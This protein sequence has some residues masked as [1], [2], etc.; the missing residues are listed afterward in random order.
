[1]KID[2]VD[3]GIHFFVSFGDSAGF[4]QIAELPYAR[5]LTL[6]RTMLSGADADVE[7]RHTLDEPTYA[8]ALRHVKEVIHF[9]ESSLNAPLQHLM[10][11]N[12]KQLA[13]DRACIVEKFPLQRDWVA[14]DGSWSES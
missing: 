14:A 11:K 8:R 3:Y 4:C 10:A 12:E 13:T 7:L 2:L 5:M 6:R 9:F 1:M